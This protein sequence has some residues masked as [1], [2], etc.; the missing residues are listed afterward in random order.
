MMIWT[1]SL[2]LIAAA[3]AGIFCGRALHAAG[4]AAPNEPR[5]EIVDLDDETAAEGAPLNVSV[6][7]TA[8]LPATEEPA[9]T[10][11]E[12]PEIEIKTVYD[13]TDI[14]FEYIPLGTTDN[15]YCYAKWGPGLYPHRY[16]TGMG[17]GGEPGI[18]TSG[19]DLIVGMG[20][21]EP[22]TTTPV[23][24]TKGVPASGTG[25]AGGAGG[26]GGGGGAQAG[27]NIGGSGA[28]GR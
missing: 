18:T 22:G 4:D 10:S 2:L 13:S 28:G 24:Y 27:G 16:D 26:E 8:P 21:V 12:T 25:G 14:Q 7:E 6:D 3:A 5:A 17:L 23:A 20:A 11:A 15:P 1:R 9:R 19:K